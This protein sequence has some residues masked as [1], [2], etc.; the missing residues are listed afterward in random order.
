MPH[1]ISAM[2]YSLIQTH[3][4][5]Y[6]EI[7]KI[8]SDNDAFKNLM[9]D[10]IYPR[11]TDDNT[12]ILTDG[13]Q[14]RGVDA[15]YIRDLEDCAQIDIINFKYRTTLK[16]CSKNFEETE[17]SK[18]FLFITELLDQSEEQKS[19]C[20][21]QV[22]RKIDDITSIFKSGKQC[23]FRIVL[24]TNGQALADT[25]LDHLVQFCKLRD[26]TSF[27]QIDGNSVV[28]FLVQEST[29]AQE[30][31]IVKVIDK[32]IFDRSDGDIRGLVACVEINSFLD[33]ISD[34]STK[35]VKRYLFDD[36]IRVYL[37]DDGGY[38]RA[39]M[40]SCLSPENHLFW[41][42]N[43]GVTVVCEAFSY[44]KELRDPM[45]TIKN[46]QIVNG[47]QTCH[48][49]L[50]ARE[51]D[52]LQVSE[53]LLLLKVYETSRRDISQRVAIATNSQARISMR[54]L[55]SNDDIQKTIEKFYDG[56]G[57]FYERKKNQHIDKPTNQRIDALKLGQMILSYKIREP[58]KAK[59]E[60]EEIFGSRYTNV[61]NQSLTADYILALTKIMAFIQLHSETGLKARVDSKVYTNIVSYGFWHLAYTISI[62]SEKEL[63]V[64]PDD[65]ELEEKLAEA[66]EIIFSILE[67]HKSFSYYDMF[68]SA[69]LRELI[70]AKIGARHQFEFG[71]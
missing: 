63:K 17:L 29:K 60:S 55:H 71:F 45:L 23:F 54:D 25:G 19:N 33:A 50:K 42:C 46:F 66:A 39:I 8:E 41:Y 57:F 36:N 12:A 27:E 59:R 9:L 13:P 64:F 3:I 53:T 2:H 32:Q 1:P 47:A 52:A 21:Q 34:L 51:I 5:K 49:L 7:F 61:F 69:Q 67:R 10:K 26:F 48:S 28:K 44:Q 43:N 30:T 58:E 16:S 22:R 20:N 15:I 37:G 65:S 56:S 62:L 18:I 6:K 35:S 70:D 14:D 68:R 24:C 40:A 38:N 4:A 11:K 31:A